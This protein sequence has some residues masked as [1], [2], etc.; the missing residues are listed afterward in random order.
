MT[1]GANKRRKDSFL[2]IE[3]V[4]QVPE[5]W[6]LDIKQNYSTLEFCEA[7]E[8]RVGTSAG[9]LQDIETLTAQRLLNEGAQIKRLSPEAR[10]FCTNPDN[11]AALAREIVGSVVRAHNLKFDHGAKRPLAMVGQ[12]VVRRRTPQALDARL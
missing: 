11:H 8:W 12:K 2:I 6:L 1:R 4:G 9:D 5:Q 7:V 3:V 10:A